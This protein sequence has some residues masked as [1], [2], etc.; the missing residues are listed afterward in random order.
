MDGRSSTITATPRADLQKAGFLIGGGQFSHFTCSNRQPEIQLYMFEKSLYAYLDRWVSTGKAPPP[1][2]DPVIENGQYV[3]DADGNILGGLRIPEMEV[4]IATYRGVLTPSADCTSAVQ[5]F[6]ADRL[7]Q[8]YP[9]HKAYAS[10]FERAVNGL[11]VKGFLARADAR[12][13]TAQAKAA[14]VP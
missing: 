11:V 14:P 9:T 6:S 7:R 12:K 1:A 8:L 13:L 2:P 10:A 4:P 5:P 3:L